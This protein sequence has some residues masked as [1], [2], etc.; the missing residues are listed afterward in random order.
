MLLTF[1]APGI[2]AIV[3]IG[4]PMRKAAWYAVTAAMVFLTSIA[5]S[6]VV[7]FAQGVN[8]NNGLGPT[9]GL[10]TMLIVNI[11]MIA[12]AANTGKKCPACQSRIHP[13]AIRCPKC[14][15]NLA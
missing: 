7:G 13:K 15:A 8:G 4:S 1:V 9:I 14:Q 12:A 6:F 2:A 5:V 3:A 11:A 10:F